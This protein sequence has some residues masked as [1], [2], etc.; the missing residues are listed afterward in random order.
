[1]IDVLEVISADTL[2][3]GNEEELKAGLVPSLP[4]SYIVAHRYQFAE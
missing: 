3:C 1:M 2:T 4:K